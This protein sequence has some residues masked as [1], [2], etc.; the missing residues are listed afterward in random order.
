MRYEG[1]HLIVDNCAMAGRSSKTFREEGRLD[2]IKVHMKEEDYL[3]FRFGHNDASSSKPE[4]FV[5]VEDFASSLLTFIEAAKEKE[6]KAGSSLIH[7]IMS[8]CEDTK[9]GEKGEIAGQLPEYGGVMRQLAEQEQILFIDMG[10]ITRAFIE[11]QENGEEYYMP[12]HVHLSP[13][14]E[15]DVMQ[16]CWQ[17]N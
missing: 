9:I 14:K 1:H 7:R 15:P 17:K 3:L 13:K 10:A 5:A 6:Y 4:R 11:A 8:V 12:D 16:S 2:D